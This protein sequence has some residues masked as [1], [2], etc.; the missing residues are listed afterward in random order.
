MKTLWLNLFAL[1]AVAFSVA[2]LLAGNLDRTEIGRKAPQSQE[3][4][5][6]GSKAK[7]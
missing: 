6:N 3:V 2:L 1:V 7:L 4:K 5:V